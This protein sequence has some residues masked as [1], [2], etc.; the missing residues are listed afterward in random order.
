MVSVLIYAI[1]LFS[2]ILIYIM[3]AQA[4]LSWFVRDPSSKAAKFY[5]ALAKITDPISAPARAFLARIG[6]DRG[7][8]DFSLLLTIIFIELIESAVIRLLITIA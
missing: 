4:L 1:R 7:M 2:R 6:A 3:I 5:M 8:L